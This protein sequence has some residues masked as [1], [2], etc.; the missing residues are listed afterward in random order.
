M[1]DKYQNLVEMLEKSVEDYAGRELFGTKVG[2]V[3]RWTTYGEFGRLV[4]AFRAGL[5]ARGVGKGDK[6]ACIANNRV[7]WAVAAYAVY[8][9]EAVFVP[10]YEA[11]A[12]KEWQFI[13]KDCE[14]KVL[15]VSS[16]GIFAKT[17]GYI[18]SIPSL[19]HVIA[20]EGS[21]NDPNTYESVLAEGRLKPVKAVKPNK[22]SLCGFIYTS[23]TTGE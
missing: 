13:L 10:M 4:D 14:A 11:Q 21:T 23:G 17:S 9:L 6:V 1:A 8:G 15:L 18:G 22:E 7:E 16:Q 20:F 5:A 3:W 19:K 12:E 2:D